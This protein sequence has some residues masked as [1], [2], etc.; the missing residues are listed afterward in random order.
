MFPRPRLLSLAAFLLF[1]ALGFPALAQDAAEDGGSVH[2]YTTVAPSAPDTR[3]LELAE[4]IVARK[5]RDELMADWELAKQRKPLS[6]IA[7]LE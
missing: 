2:A 4:S 7:P 6:P 1:S 5:E 3:M